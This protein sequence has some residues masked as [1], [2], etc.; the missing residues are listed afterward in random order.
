[1]A[2]NEDD[3]RILLEEEYERQ[4]E[5]LDNLINPFKSWADE[6]LKRS[7]LLLR[8]GSGIN[9]MYM[10]TLIPHIIKCLKLLPS[11]AT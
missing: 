8:K 1:M 2:E 11:G 10:P 7:E 4:Y 6:I 5:G 3:A 9:A